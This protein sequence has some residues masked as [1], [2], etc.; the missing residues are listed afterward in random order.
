MTQPAPVVLLCMKDSVAGGLCLPPSWPLLRQP[1]ARSA[2]ENLADL[3]LLGSGQ[4]TQ[5][6]GVSVL[7]ADQIFVYVLFIWVHVPVRLMQQAK[8]FLLV[9]MLLGEE[10]CVRAGDEAGESQMWWQKGWG[11]PPASGAFRAWDLSHSSPN[12]L[13]LV[14]ASFHDA[15]EDLTCLNARKT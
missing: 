1:R 12:N 2:A 11:N 6:S 15:S 7:H 14:V 10:S 4:D 5:G 3:R 9:R 13:R 8:A